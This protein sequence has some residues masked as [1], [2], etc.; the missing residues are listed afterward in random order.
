MLKV[1]CITGSHFLNQYSVWEGNSNSDHVLINLN[2]G[3]TY[4]WLQ[5]TGQCMKCWSSPHRLGKRF[6]VLSI[7][8]G[9]L[10]FLYVSTIVPKWNHKLKVRKARKS[11]IGVYHMWTNDEYTWHTY[12]QMCIHTYRRSCYTGSL[13]GIQPTTPFKSCNFGLGS[14]EKFAAI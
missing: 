13:T 6:N 12:I 9:I 5:W 4:Q 1:L 7:T 2:S 10:N 8:N 3:L 14:V 11:V